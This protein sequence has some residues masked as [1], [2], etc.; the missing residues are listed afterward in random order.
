MQDTV[1]EMS[2]LILSQKDDQIRRYC[3]GKFTKS[4]NES[5]KSGMY[6][7]KNVHLYVKCLYLNIPL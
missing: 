7:I 2:Q 6:Y 1:N 5:I 3:S 4:S